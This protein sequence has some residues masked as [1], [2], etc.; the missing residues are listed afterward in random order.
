MRYITVMLKGV[1]HLRRNT[2]WGPSI[3]RRGQFRMGA[4]KCEE[5]MGF[6]WDLNF[7]GVAKLRKSAL[8][9]QTPHGHWPM[10]GETLPLTVCLV[11][12]YL[13]LWQKL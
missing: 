6:S 2:R 13:C 3:N 1:C 11:M 10:Q 5:F 7:E 9:A 12:Q 8:S 4:S